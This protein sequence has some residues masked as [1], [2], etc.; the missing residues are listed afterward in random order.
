MTCVN[1]LVLDGSEVKLRLEAERAVTGSPVHID[2]LRFT[3]NLRN[4][5]QPD[6]DDLF[7]LPP[8]AAMPVGLD[9]D[10]WYAANVKDGRYC[11]RF[12]N[13]LFRWEKLQDLRKVLNSLPD[14]DF[15][16]S[17]QAKEL[18]VRVA[19]ALGSDF[20]LHPELLKGHDFYRFRWSIVRNGDKEVAWVG[21]LA[22]STSPRQKSQ[23]STIH[24]N[25]TGTACT[26]AD[27]RWPER[28]A[29]LIEDTNAKI[30]RCDLALDFFGGISGGLGRVKSDY[31][32]GLMNVRGNCPKCN[33]IGVWLDT[34]G[35]SR[36]FYF[37]SKEAG[38]QTNVYEK[39]HQLYGPV[40]ANPWQ[41]IE[42]RYGNKLRVLSVDMLRRPADF[43]AGA[44][45]WHAALLAEHG[46]VA[47]PESVTVKARRALET[48]R[49]EVSRNVRWLLNTAAPSVAL[50]FQHLGDDFLD[51]VTGKSAPGRLQSFHS[52]EISNAYA[53]AFSR[54]SSGSRSGGGAVPA[55]APS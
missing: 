45:D 41:R 23:A 31:E 53:S 40:S 4:A 36:S 7:P 52:D 21:F 22:S 11:P 6:V 2:W 42:L 33:M 26:F 51:L 14:A 54:I 49:A 3:V 1:P 29:A 24:V 27:V 48:V 50:A 43:F 9:L 10:S 32:A 30:T 18:A 55:F 37:G 25:L 17:A 15:S 35:H 44:S 47:A 12:A 13:D 34:G 16:A 38:K 5:P 39:G 46:T 19:D 28:I 20:S 8:P